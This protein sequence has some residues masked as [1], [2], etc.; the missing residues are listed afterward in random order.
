VKANKKTPVIAAIVALLALIGVGVALINAYIE[1]ERQRD[2]LQWE[3]RLGLV[4]DGKEDAC[5]A[6][7]PASGGSGGLADNARCASTVAGHPGEKRRPRP[8][9]LNRLG[10]LRN[11]GRRALRL[12]GG[13]W[14]RV[15]ANVPQPR[16][17]GIALLDVSYSRWCRRRAW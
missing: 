12:H 5:I 11:S 10:R 15:P 8:A 7:W 9:H 13:E 3:S 6:C 2:L 17:A 4:A 14:R 1:Q 16:A